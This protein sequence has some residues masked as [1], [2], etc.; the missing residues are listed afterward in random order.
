LRKTG[1]Y[2]AY[3]S[4][5]DGRQMRERC[6]SSLPLCRARLPGHSL[7]FTYYSTRWKGGAADVVPC[8]ED[9]AS[10]NV[11]WGVVYQLDVEEL[12]LL[13]RYEIGYDRVPIAV[14]DDRDRVHPVLS[15]SVR[16]KGRF[17]PSDVY[18]QKLISWGRRWR[19]PDT[20][21]EKL[22]SR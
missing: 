9:V 17:A 14:I 21:L 7:D 1:L 6:P 5:L 13:D 16:E 8:S 15:Y 4:N 19:F 11:V 10:E 2:F 12:A 3:G 20:Y 18:L 22:G